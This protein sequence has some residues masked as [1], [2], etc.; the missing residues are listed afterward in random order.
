MSSDK[1]LKGFTVFSVI[2]FC[3]TLNASAGW[4]KK[5]KKAAAEKR[6]VEAVVSVTQEST[7]APA[8]GFTPPRAVILP[9]GFNPNPP[10][11]P[12]KPITNPV[13]TSLPP[14][15]NP[16]GYSGALT[17]PAATAA[18]AQPE[19]VKAEEDK[20]AA[21]VAEPAAEEKTAVAEEDATDTDYDQD[22]E[23]A[24]DYAAEPVVAEDK[25]KEAQR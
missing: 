23:E 2:V 1:F 13:N 12:G 20:D 7:P 11:N 3:F 14:G 22:M 21:V 17:V 5:K 19:A 25:E 4:S 16:P 8:Q 15:F 18:A 24:D 6:K 10:A 9:P